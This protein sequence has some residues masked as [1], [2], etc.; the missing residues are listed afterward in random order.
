MNLEQKEIKVPGYEKVMQFKDIDA[1]L[2][3]IIAIHNTKLGPGLGGVRIYPYSTFEDALTDVLR[4]SKGMTYKASLAQIGFGGAKGVIIADP[5]TDKTPALLHSFAEAVN[6]L[7]GKYIC[8]EDIGSTSEDI[9][10]ILEKTKY[11]CGV[12]NFRGSGSPSPFT[13]WGILQGIKS[14]FMH[15][16]NHA[17]LEG[18]KVAIQG[19]GSVGH[20]V[21][22]HL[23]WEGAQLI[24]SDTDKKA[25]ASCFQQ[26]G[27]Q[28][29]PPREILFV[30]CDILAPCAMGGTINQETI[31]KLRCRGIAGSA[32]NQLLEEADGER[33]IEREI[34]YAPDFVINAG[35]V[36]NLA[37]ELSS[38]GY[39]APSARRVTKN[40]YQQL[41]NIYQ[42]AAEKKISTHQVAISIC[43]HHL[44]QGIGKRIED[45]VFR[46]GPEK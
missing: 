40:I 29:V 9:S 13:A 3:A 21:M 5:K 7:N 14:V 17:S 30:D 24:V 46:F 41:L 25:V 22:K 2:I 11:A 44:K 28:V 16:E 31:P 26:Y 23:F 15:L 43:D 35:G 33:L 4:L 37:H 32:N 36:I 6:T 8:A 38:D 42:T 27:A 12:F 39:Q 45:P 10:I 18:K 19:V 20:R 34:L 1:G